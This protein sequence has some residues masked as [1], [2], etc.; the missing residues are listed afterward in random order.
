MLD[1]NL[2]FSYLEQVSKPESQ[3]P[4]LGITSTRG[5]NFH[6]TK[7]PTS[8]SSFYSQ[9]WTQCQEH[10]SCSSLNELMNEYVPHAVTYV[11][12]PIPSF[13]LKDTWS[14]NNF[15]INFPFIH[16]SFLSAHKYV[17]ISPLKFKLEPKY[18]LTITPSSYCPISLL[19]FVAKL[20]KRAI[21][22]WCF[23]FLIS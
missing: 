18:I 5:F 16:G 22:T 8:C 12:D 6:V 15:I 2:P 21:H 17:I 19:S 7:E 11:L 3:Y 23:K 14:S 9:D 20:L 10:N 4:H 13:L 1:S